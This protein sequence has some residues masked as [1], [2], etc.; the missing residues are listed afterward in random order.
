MRR[1]QIVLIAL[2]LVFTVTGLAAA[3]QPPPPAGG[4]GGGGMHPGG[5]PM[6]C[7]MMGGG[8]MPM[9]GGGMPMMGMMGGH[10]DPKAMAQMLQL[11]GEMMKAVGDVMVRHGKTMEGAK[12]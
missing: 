1:N 9:M 7:Q 5:M 11:H 6:M 2:G 12:P 4:H 10:M 3:Q 8:A